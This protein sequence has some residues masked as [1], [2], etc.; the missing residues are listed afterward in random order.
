MGISTVTSETTISRWEV[1][2]LAASLCSDLTYKLADVWEELL[3]IQRSSSKFHPHGNF[4]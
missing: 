1:S 2:Q 4:D 3:C